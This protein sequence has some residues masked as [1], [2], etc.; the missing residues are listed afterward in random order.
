M[1][2]PNPTPLPLRLREEFVCLS[3][4]RVHGRFT[5]HLHVSTKR[6]RADPVVG[7]AFPETDEAGPKADRKRFDFDFEEF[8]HEEMAE[9]VDDN[10]DSKNDGGYGDAAE[11]AT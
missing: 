5:G 3:G 6:K 1:L 4:D 11:S 7:I 10:D 2:I 9:F 8:R